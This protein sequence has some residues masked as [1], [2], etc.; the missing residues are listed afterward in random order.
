MAKKVTAVVKL[1]CPAGAANPSPPIGPAL[2]QHG[3]NIMGFCKEFNARTKNQA[4]YIIPVVISIYS[5]RSFTFE[6]KSPP[7]AS[8]LLK[9]ANIEKGSAV[10]NKNKVGRVTMKQVEDIAKMKMADLN[11]ANIETA[12]SMVA[13]TARSMG[14][15]VD[16]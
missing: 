16:A 13:G 5:D 3:V 4:G 2:G 1:Q 14:L 12:K 6:L 15:E 10:P 7:A 8:L 9:A 11:A